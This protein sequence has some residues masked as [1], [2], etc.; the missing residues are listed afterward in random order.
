MAL[1]TNKNLKVYYSIKEVAKI[2]GVTE[3]TLRFWETEITQLKPKILPA[4]RIRQYTVEDIDLA[5]N[6]YNLVK[7][8]GFKLSAAK[9]MIS[10]N[11]TGTDRSAEVMATLASVKEELQLLKRQLGGLS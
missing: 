10:A 9:K 1:S 2:V 6:I 5:K 4:S 11:R 7:V 8:R 3:S